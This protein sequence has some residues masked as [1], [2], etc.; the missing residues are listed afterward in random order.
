MYLGSQLSVCRLINNL[1][2]AFLKIMRQE[3]NLT[4]VIC[5]E[6]KWRDVLS[7][8]TGQYCRTLDFYLKV[9]L[10]LSFPPFSAGTLKFSHT[11]WSYGTDEER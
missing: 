10:D 8:K 3:L 9:F 7:P 11:F 4:R 2:G 5:R 1:V 6:P